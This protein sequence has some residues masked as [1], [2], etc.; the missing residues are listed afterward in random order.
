MAQAPAG[1]YPQPD[2][3]Q[4]YWDGS[5]WTEH[6]SGTP[7]T[8]TV[9]T[10]PAVADAVAETPKA[11]AAAKPKAKAAAV[12]PSE[13]AAS[14]PVVI[15]SSDGPT[16]L[17][18]TAQ[19]MQAAMPVASPSDLDAAAAR[20]RKVWPIVVGVIGAIALVIIIAIVALVFLFKGLTDGPNSAVANYDTAWKTVDCELMQQSTTAYFREQNGYAD[21]ASFESN[22]Q[23]FA[24]T[25]GTYDVE[26]YNTEITGNA[27]IVR[28]TETW[29]TTDGETST[30][31]YTYKLLKNGDVWLIDELQDS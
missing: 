16:P 1:W 22:A 26:I 27:A 21:C 28:T 30:Y 4:R 25:L 10:G 31:D 14:E 11:K 20:K 8:G 24:D 3:T 13:A 29:V 6:I 18:M 12:E 2:G 7:T 23:E 9:A 5:A 17:G 15:A 19:P